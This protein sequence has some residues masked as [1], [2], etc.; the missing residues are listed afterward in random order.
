MPLRTIGRGLLSLL[1]MPASALLLLIFVPTRL[2]WWCLLQL[3]PDSNDI[4]AKV[5]VVKGKGDDK[6]LD[7]IYALLGIL[8]SKASA[9]MRYN[10]IILAVIALMVRSGQ[11]LPDIAYVIV[12]TTLASILCCLVVVGVFWRFYEFVNT[13]G[14]PLAGELRVLR[15]VL[16]L[17]EAAYQV[18]WWLAVVVSVLLIIHFAD[19]VKKATGA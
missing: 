3:L 14:N 16:V 4:D 1:R 13:T 8:D 2:I 17:R 12:Y 15:R 9:L 6:L 7:A 19:F 10:G 11:G 18:A 5:A